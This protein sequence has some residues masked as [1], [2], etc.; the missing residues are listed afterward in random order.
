MRP[1]IA[2][3]VRHFR[4]FRHFEPFKNF[5]NLELNPTIFP[6]THS[7][8]LYTLRDQHLNLSY[9][10]FLHHKHPKLF[11]TSIDDLC[12]AFSTGGDQHLHLMA[13]ASN[14]CQLDSCIGGKNPGCILC[15]QRKHLRLNRTGQ[16]CFPRKTKMSQHTVKTV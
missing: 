11:T 1:Q 5:P 10:L 9:R 12:L 8:S 16:R 7:Y 3:E 13:E 14:S 2:W 6:A 4:H 15:V